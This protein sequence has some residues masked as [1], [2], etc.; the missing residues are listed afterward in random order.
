MYKTMLVA[1]AAL[2]ACAAEARAALYGYEGFNYAAGTLSGKGSASDPGFS[3]AWTQ[4]TDGGNVVSGG[5]SYANLQTTGGALDLAGAGTTLNFRGLS[6]A[7]NDPSDTATGEL[8]FSYL[9]Q[10]GTYTGLP[11][12]GLSFYTD[13]LTGSTATDTDFYLAARN[14]SPGNY[15]YGDLDAANGAQTPVIATPGETVLL[16]GQIVFGAGANTSATNEDH[17]Y[18]YA[19]PAIGGDIPAPDADTDLTADFQTMRLAAQNGAN[20]LVD[21][22]RIGDS[23]A[24]VTPVIPPDPNVDGAPGITLNDFQVIRTNF[25]TGT[26]HAQGDVNYDGLVDHAD[27]YLWRTSF[28]GTG[29]TLEGVNLWGVP[30]PASGVAALV[31]T[32]AGGLVVRQARRAKRPA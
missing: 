17:I 7:Y 23:F 6:Q 11:F 19:N 27:F 9:I 16:V 21:E 20:F 30:E 25:L 8:W 24:D 5:L 29:A 14:V 13:Q 3:T 28:L 4:G 12:A 31:M 26:T 2:L 18:I 22:F 15:G 32:L 1:A 10:P